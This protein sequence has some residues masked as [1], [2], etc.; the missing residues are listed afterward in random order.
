MENVLI[1]VCADVQEKRSQEALIGSPKKA[2]YSHVPG[3]TQ[4]LYVVLLSAKLSIHR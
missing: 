4:A 1:P 2:M 3:R